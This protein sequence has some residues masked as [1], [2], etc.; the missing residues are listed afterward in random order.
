M[1]A[2]FF[3]TISRITTGTLAM[4]LSMIPALKCVTYIAGKYSLRRTVGVQDK[5]QIPIIS[6][7]TQQLPIQHALAQIA[8]MEPFANQIIAWFTDLSLE[9]E[10]RNGLAVILKA[11]FVEMAQRS[12]PQL[13]E[14][15]GAQ[16]LFQHNQV[17]EFDVSTEI[18]YYA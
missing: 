9:A 16:G 4:S 7:R 14:R 18:L 3:N 5:M 12:I 10:V 8:V 6:F 15:C 17:Y 11:V 1:R 13:I 2:Q